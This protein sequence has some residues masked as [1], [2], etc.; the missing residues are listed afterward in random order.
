LQCGYHNN[1][2]WLMREF[3]KRPYNE[4]LFWAFK[5]QKLVQ[6][7]K[8]PTPQQAVAFSFEMAPRF[9][10]QQNSKRLPFGCHAWSKYDRGFWEPYLLK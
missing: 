2:R 8:I 10:F 4:D 1:V 3:G 5:A 7:F 6:H 9:C